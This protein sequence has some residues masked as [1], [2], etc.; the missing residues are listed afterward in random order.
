LLARKRI[1][2]AYYS[3]CLEKCKAIGHSV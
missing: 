3:E 1:P 2:Q